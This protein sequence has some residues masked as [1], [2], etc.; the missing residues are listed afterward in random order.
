MLT[1]LVRRSHLRSAGLGLAAAA[2]VAVLV[3]GTGSTASAAGDYGKDTCL[4]GYT[5]RETIPTDHV[6][7]TPAARAQAQADNAAAAQRRWGTGCQPDY[8]WRGAIATGEAD[9]EAAVS[10]AYATGQDPTVYVQA[11]F[12]ALAANDRVCVTS[13]VRSQT[14]A[15]NNAWNTRVL[16]MSVDLSPYT[17]PVTLQGRGFNAGTAYVA[18][19]RSSDNTVLWQTWISTSAGADFTVTAPFDTCAPYAPSTPVY[20]TAYDYT[21]GVWRTGPTR[22]VC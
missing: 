16:R 22:E 14:V 3:V 5:W 9:L 7:V 4:E 21:A 1:S 20:L 6:C 13:A 2:S 19:V 11:H 15:D 8:T 17:A 12:D 18:V 10:F